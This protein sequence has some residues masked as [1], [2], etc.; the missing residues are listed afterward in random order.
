MDEAF[1]KEELSHPDSLP[2]PSSYMFRTALLQEN[3]QG[4][5]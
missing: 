4:P 1:V 3:K 2:D 5:V